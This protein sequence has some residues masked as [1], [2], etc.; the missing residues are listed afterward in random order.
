MYAAFRALLVYRH[1]SRDGL[2]QEHKMSTKTSRN[3]EKILRKSASP[4]DNKAMPV[5]PTPTISSAKKAT[6]PSRTPAPLSAQSATV[7]NKQTQ[8]IAMLRLPEGATLTD[9]MEATGWQAH[10]VRGV[11]SGALRKRL[12]LTVTSEKTEDGTRCYRI[13]TSMPA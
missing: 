1:G 8:I 10:S 2:N 6:P 9:L 7:T 12:G 13:A 11:I 3:T 5:L 4:S